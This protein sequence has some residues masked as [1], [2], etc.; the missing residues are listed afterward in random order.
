[1]ISENIN[2]DFFQHDI[3]YETETKRADGKIIV[4]KKERLHCSENGWK[5]RSIQSTRN[6]KRYDPDFF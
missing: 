5:S 3:L 4:Q 1:M 6:Q 2:K